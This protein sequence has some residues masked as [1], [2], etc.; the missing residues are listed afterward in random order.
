MRT[1]VH[2]CAPLLGHRLQNSSPM[3]QDRCLSCLS[4]PVCDIGVLYCDCWMDQVATW[5]EGSIGHIALDGDPAPTLPQNG[6]ATLLFG[7]CLLWSNGLSPGH[8]VLDGTYQQLPLP[9]KGAQ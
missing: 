1:I 4:C 2:L 9:Q 7:P 3:L 5:Y 8:I 6:P